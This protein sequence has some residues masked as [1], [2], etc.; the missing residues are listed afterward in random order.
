MSDEYR[1]KFDV[2]GIRHVKISLYSA[3]VGVFLGAFVAHCKFLL[4]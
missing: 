1:A 2:F 4:I 3:W